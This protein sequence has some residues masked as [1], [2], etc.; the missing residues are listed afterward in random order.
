MSDERARRSAGLSVRIWRMASSRI[1]SYEVKIHLLCTQIHKSCLATP[2]ENEIIRILISTII[3]GI[4]KL[5][6]YLRT[7]HLYVSRT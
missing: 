2:T 1:Q 6:S 3:I 4:Q 7:Y 5:L